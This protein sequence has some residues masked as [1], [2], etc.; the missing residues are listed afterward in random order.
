MFINKDISKKDKII[1]NKLGKDADTPLHDLMRCAHYK[2]KSSVY[3]RIR[4]LREENFL[5]GPYFDINYNAIGE[6]KLYSIFVIVEYVPLHRKVVLEAMKAIDC[7]TMI[8]PVRT[9]QNYLGI[10]RCNNWNWIARLFRLMKKWKWIK[11]YSILK[12]ECKWIVQNPDFFADFLPPR[13]YHPMQGEIPS[14][15]FPDLEVDM[16]FA[17][18]DIIILKHLFRKTCHLTEIRDMEYKRYGLKLKYHD[19]KRHYKKLIKNKI[20]IKKYYLIFP[21]PADMCSLF[22]LFSRGKDLDSHIRLIANFGNDLRFNNTFTVTGDTVISY[23]VSHP[24]LEGKILGL[25]EDKVKFANIYGIKTYPSSELF[26]QTLN[27]E[28][29]DIKSQRWI[30]PYSKLEEQFFTLKK[31]YEDSNTY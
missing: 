13:K 23:Y 20:L 6:N 11:E 28:Y 30:F 4:H 8:Y 25:L 10:Y 17:N 15:H 3:N 21:L 1:L 22:F 7:W 14:Y 12:S 2:R 16:E 9:A 29:F 18:I 26:T 27:D 5:Y 19:L 24:L 31:E